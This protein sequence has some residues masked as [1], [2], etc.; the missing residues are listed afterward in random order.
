LLCKFLFRQGQQILSLTLALEEIL[1][2]PPLS[3]ELD[4]LV[5]G[6]LVGD[7]VVASE[8]E[9]LIHSV[10]QNRLSVLGDRCA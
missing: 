7:A 6:A 1:G 8:R 9:G 4:A 2:L 10:V 5:I 3:N